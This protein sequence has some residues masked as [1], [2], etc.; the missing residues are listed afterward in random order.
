MGRILSIDFGERQIGLAISDET[1]TIAQGLE[2]LKVQSEKGKG[3]DKG[4]G[5]FSTSTSTSTSPCDEL[6]F[7]DAV[8]DIARVIKEREVE[9][10]ILGYPLSLSGKES[11]GSRRVLK[12][13]TWLERR[14]GVPIELVDERFTTNLAHQYLT[15]AYPKTLSRKHAVDKVAATILLEDYL[16]QESRRKERGGVDNETTQV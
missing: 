12:F 1:R 2:T 15:E 4:K 6:R 13:K 9:R 8:A 14:A 10:V 5:S 16:A 11:R 3:K 7:R